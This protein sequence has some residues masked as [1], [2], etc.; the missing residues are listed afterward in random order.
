MLYSTVHL[1][2]WVRMKEEY[3]ASHS[4]HRQPQLNASRITDQP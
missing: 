4:S 2:E 3:D 1:E